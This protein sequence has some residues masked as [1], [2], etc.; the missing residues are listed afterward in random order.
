M[1]KLSWFA[2]LC[3]MGL[4]AAAPSADARRH[5]HR[6]HKDK[7]MATKGGAAAEVAKTDDLNA[8]SLANATAAKPAGR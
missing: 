2:A 7:A 6:Q 3:A 4:M 8:K 1:R 5:H